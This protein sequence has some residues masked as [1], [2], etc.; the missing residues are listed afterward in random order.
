MI[1]FGWVQCHYNYYNRELCFCVYELM[2]SVLFVCEKK[3]DIFI[4]RTLDIRRLITVANAFCVGLMSASMRLNF[5]SSVFIRLL[6]VVAVTMNKLLFQ[7][8]YAHMLA[9]EHAPFRLFVSSCPWTGQFLFS[10]I[11]SRARSLVRACLISE[12]CIWMDRSKRRDCNGAW[13]GLVFKCVSCRILAN[14]PQR[15]IDHKTSSDPFTQTSTMSVNSVIMSHLQ[16][17][18]LTT[19]NDRIADL[20]M[21]IN[22]LASSIAKLQAKNELNYYKRESMDVESADLLFN[23]VD[24]EHEIRSNDN[25]LTSKS[26]KYSLIPSL[27]ISSMST[28]SN[29]ILVKLC[30]LPNSLLSTPLREALIKFFLLSTA[31]DDI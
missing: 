22:H 12:L 16:N 27:S 30:N 8:F 17:E 24:N 29:S 23:D 14:Q 25:S 4:S 2:L 31:K 13:I 26:A 6:S 28:E 21:Q 19:L 1:T 9:T 15:K 18:V 11:V 20:Q 3:N 10:Y 5:D 7:S